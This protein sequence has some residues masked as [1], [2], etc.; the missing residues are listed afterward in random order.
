MRTLITSDHR[1][2]VRKEAGQYVARFEGQ[3]IGQATDKRD[4][5]ALALDHKRKQV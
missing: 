4:A 5:N 3:W 2:T 1:Y